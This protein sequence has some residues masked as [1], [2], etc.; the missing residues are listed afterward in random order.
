MPAA[1]AR[2]PRQGVNYK[3]EARRL[4]R[5]LRGARLGRRYYCPP[6]HVTEKK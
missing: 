4:R 2:A 5:Q 1:D 6:V 3:P